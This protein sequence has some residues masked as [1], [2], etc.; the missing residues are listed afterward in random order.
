MGSAL[1]G[2]IQLTSGVVQGS[3]IGPLLFVLFINDVVQAVG[4]SCHS[5]IYADD[6]KIYTEVTTQHEE[7][8]LQTG[9][10]ALS[11]W[12]RDWQLTIS[13]KK[14]AILNIHQNASV[15]PRDYLLADAVVPVRTSVKD[16]GVTVD[17]EL[18]LAFTSVAALREH[19]QDRI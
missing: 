19:I 5:K 9:L 17:N 8:L 16:L 11:T 14:C 2:E 1:S 13:A 10:D 6:L 15:Q 3:C 4:Y 18:S 7:D 12:S